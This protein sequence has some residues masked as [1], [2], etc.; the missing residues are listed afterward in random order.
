MR[1]DK[2][3]AFN[4]RSQGKTYSEIH[5]L[6]A[7]PIGTLS[8][9]F[10]KD[11]AFPDILSNNRQ[12]SRKNIIKKVIAMNEGRKMALSK[13]YEKARFEAEKEF[14]EQKSD[15][16]FLI[17]L[18]LYWG[19]GD[20]RNRHQIKISNT[21]PEVIRIFKLFLEKILKVDKIKIKA[22]LLLYP[23]LDDNICRA[24]WMHRLGLSIENFYKS[25]VTQGRQKRNHLSYGVC[26]LGFSSAYLKQKVLT[27]VEILG[28]ETI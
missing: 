9:W 17:A 13:L 8:S 4:L 14:Q 15:P 16:L 6:L 5:S 25:T 23:D 19:E 3:K 21:D 22:W 18:S 27:W 10:G 24:Y 12:E 28:R 20:K 1:K 7:I 26:S 2:E 11:K